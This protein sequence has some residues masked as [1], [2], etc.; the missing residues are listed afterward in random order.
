MSDALAI[1]PEKASEHPVFKAMAS[2]S[3]EEG[4]RTFCD[5]HI[6][7]HSLVREYQNPEKKAMRRKEQEEM[8]KGFEVKEFEREA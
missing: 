3:Q 5:D 8:F 2:T 1:Q 4:R 7:R 6:I